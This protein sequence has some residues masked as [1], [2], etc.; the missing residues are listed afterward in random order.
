LKK[1]IILSILASNLLLAANNIELEKITI[2]AA[3]KGSQTLK[4]ITSNVEV[5]TAEE[6]EEKHY[7]TI[8]EA[9]S[10]LA[11]VNFVQSGGMGTTTSVL[12]RGFD[13]KY[14]LVL[15][16]G[17]KYNEAASATG[18]AQFGHLLVSDIERIELIK[19]ANPIWGADAAAGVINIVTKK[20]A[21]GFKSEVDL[22]AGSYNTKS[23]KASFGYGGDKFALSGG[24]SRYLADGFSAQAPRGAKDSN[25]ERDG[26]Q[27]TAANFKASYELAKN[28]KIDGELY[29]TKG[30]ASYDG[31]N[32]PNAVQRS[33]YEYTMKKSG[34]SYK[35]ASHNL[36]LQASNAA[37]KRDELDTTALNSVKIFKGNVKNYELKDDW[38]Y[39]AD[40]N[41]LFGAS[42]ED[43]EI[44]YTAIGAREIKKEDSTRSV[45]AA[46]TNSYG[47]LV[48]T[49]AVRYDDY[50]TFGSK[51]NAK[52]GAKYSLTKDLSLSSNYGTAFKTPTLM[53]MTNPWGTAN[54]DLKPENI[55]SFDAGAA[56]KKFS[57][58]YF[59]NTISNLIN[60]QGSGYTN[61]G[62]ISTL[63]GYE[64]KWL[65]QI[66]ET[67]TVNVAYTRLKAE[68]SARREI[69]RRPHDTLTLNVDWYPTS[70]L[71]I[72]LNSVYIG[73]RYDTNTK[74]TQTGGY[75]VVGGVIN[76]QIN[77]RFTTYAKF[78]NLLDKYYQN[79]AG[80]VSPGRSA[81]AGLKASF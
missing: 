81:Y 21:N 77:R 12:V 2:T 65:T 59:Y 15:I 24:V 1:S 37:S 9:I 35:L 4:S 72:G 62:G 64:A 61:I 17:V 10:S 67:I 78:E 63:Q 13:T 27:N 73:T 71:H 11:G 58:T 6:I 52:A 39:L 48:L 54:F 74:A 69:A 80:Y 68:D 25:Y 20:A 22:M 33:A 28:L 3:S 16:D 5:I 38:N 34:L 19:G 36:S 26:Y 30:T 31:F 49:E 53:Q 18:E 44:K 46:N 60:W 23:A 51:T 75:A 56:Y 47:A 70:A 43:S 14:T 40:S 79:V 42:R 8:T 55:R 57:L 66:G 29:T 45:F 32:A 76:Y 7:A 50:S 41:L